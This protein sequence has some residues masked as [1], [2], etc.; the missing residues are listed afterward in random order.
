MLASP[1]NE[2]LP[3]IR[4]L[5]EPVSHARNSG[6]NLE[7]ELKNGF[8]PLKVALIVFNNVKESCE[9]FVSS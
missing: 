8:H 6:G 7:N 1:V 2:E 5:I 4:I 9:P 3:F